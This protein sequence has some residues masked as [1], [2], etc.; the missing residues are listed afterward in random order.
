MHR[1]IRKILVGLKPGLKLCEFNFEHTAEILKSLIQKRHET[2]PHERSDLIL[3]E[4]SEDETGLVCVLQYDPA[5]DTVVG[6]CGWRSP[7]HTCDPDFAPVVGDSWD[8]L[9][10]IM[11]TSVAATY[12]RVIM[13]NPLVDWIKPI[14]LYANATC[15]KFKHSGHRGD[16]VSQ[17]ARTLMFST[18][19]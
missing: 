10:R 4:M 1:H 3:C 11:K 13:L 2:H 9:I 19:I 15:N 7:D 8:N 18:N 14:V 12:A 17:W 16:V 6:S 5:T